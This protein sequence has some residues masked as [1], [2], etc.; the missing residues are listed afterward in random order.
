VEEL[1]VEVGNKAIPIDSL[2]WKDN[3]EC[4]YLGRVVIDLNGTTSNRSKIKFYVNKFMV[5]SGLIDSIRFLKLLQVENVWITLNA[6]I[7]KG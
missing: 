5:S 3:F 2:K 4:L 6:Y 1:W 7:S